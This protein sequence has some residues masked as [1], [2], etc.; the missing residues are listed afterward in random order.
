MQSN[1]QDLIRRLSHVIAAVLTITLSSCISPNDQFKNTTHPKPAELRSKR[2]GVLATAY[3]NGVWVKILEID[4]KTTAGDF[5]GVPEP[6]LLSPGAHIL[7]ITI[8]GSWSTYVDGFVKISVKPENKYVLRGKHVG[9][10]FVLEVVNTT[11]GQEVVEES[12]R[13]VQQNRRTSMYIPVVV[14]S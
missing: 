6:Y 11:S 10:V 4:G 13:V 1:Y 14:S 9:S 8:I 3:A 12:F 2:D 5:V 7:A